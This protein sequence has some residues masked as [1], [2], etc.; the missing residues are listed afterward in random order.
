MLFIDSLLQPFRSVWQMLYI[1]HCAACGQ[2]LYKQEEIICLFCQ[3]E[4]PITNYH[5]DVDNPLA[6]R[7]WG[8]VQLENAATYL[9][10]TKGGRVQQLIHR[11]KYKNDTAVGSFLGAQY[12]NIL[13]QS[14]HFADIDAVI[15]IPLHRRKLRKRGFNQSEIIAASL[16]QTLQKPM[17]SNVVQRN[18]DTETQTRKGRAERWQNVSSVF[19]ITDPSALSNKHLL[20]VDDVITTGATI[21]ACATELLKLPNVRLSVVGIASATY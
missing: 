14:P 3:Q 8:R 10:F 18:A 12:G 20:L 7:F 6:K 9:N 4:L 11:L 21:E 17:L 19:A 5:N 1:E 15:P 16:A 2:R 13:R